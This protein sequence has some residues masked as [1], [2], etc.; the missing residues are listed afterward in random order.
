MTATETAQR[1]L[2]ITPR[3]NGLNLSDEKE[4]I[5]CL[6]CVG[7]DRREYVTVRWYA[8]RRR[9]ASVVYCSVWVHAPGQPGT[10]GHGKAGGGG[11]CKQSAAMDAALGSAGVKLAESIGGRGMMACREAAEAMARA[12]GAAEPRCYGFGF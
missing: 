3:E 2:E 7:E 5:A 10:S 6:S 4:C 8:S 1:V 11:Y 12:V 9:D